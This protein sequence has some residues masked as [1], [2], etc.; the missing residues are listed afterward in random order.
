VNGTWLQADTL[1][2]Y[3][4]LRQPNCETIGV[5]SA[6]RGSRRPKPEA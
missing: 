6:V 2:P 3:A 5:Q 4:S 1:R